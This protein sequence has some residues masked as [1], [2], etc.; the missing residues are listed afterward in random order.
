MSTEPQKPVR[1]ITVP[2]IAARKGG[3][4]IVSLTSYHAHTAAIVDRYADFILVGDSLGMVMHGMETTI[5]VPLDLMIMH[6][7]AVVRGTKR[8]LVVVDMPFGT[9]E[10]SPQV[11]F[12]NAAQIMKETQC[13]AVKLEGGARMAETIRFLTERGIPV[14]AHIGL[15]PQSSHTMGGFKTQ[16]REEDSWPAHEAD[17]KAVAE[18]GAFA[19]VLEGMVEPLAAKITKQV[20][21]PTIGIGASAECDGQILVLEDMLGLNPKPPKFVKVYGRLGEEIENAVRGYAE[22]VRARSFPTDD[23]TYR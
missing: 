18:A 19:L 21:I 11:A 10:E 8:A 20:A 23:Q 16:G 17:A 9:Y 4:P 3:E 13:G 7:R 14:M 1:R 22:D 6:G 2:Q 15:T 5:G 12:R